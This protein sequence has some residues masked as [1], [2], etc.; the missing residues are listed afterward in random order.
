MTASLDSLQAG[1]VWFAARPQFIAS[2]R[3]DV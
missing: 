3:E 2:M 1:R